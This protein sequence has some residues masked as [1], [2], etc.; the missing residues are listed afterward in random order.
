[1]V[2]LAIREC[3][4]DMHYYSFNLSEF[5]N[6]I[7]DAL[8]H[9]VPQVRCETLK[10]IRASIA[11]TNGATLSDVKPFSKLFVKVISLSNNNISRN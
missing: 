5:F 11:K 10:W 6:E 7:S 4:D 8:N 3:L 1:M 9:K 2:L